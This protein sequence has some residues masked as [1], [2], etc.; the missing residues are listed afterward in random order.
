[1]RSDFAEP[2]HTMQEA[3]F[4]G[5]SKHRVF[6]NYHPA[7]RG[8]GRILAIICPPLFFEYMHVHSALRNLAI[9]LSEGGQ[10]VLRLDYRGTGDSFGDLE[11]FSVS[12]WVD[13]IKLAVQEGRKISGSDGVH[14]VAVRA[15]ALL[16]CRSMDA[17]DGVR[18]LVLWD[19]VAD[20]ATYLRELRDVQ[21]RCIEQHIYMSRADRVEAAQE[22][23][24]HRVSNRMIE[25]FAALD[26]NVYASIPKN[27]LYVICTREAGGLHLNGHSRVVIPPACDWAAIENRI[28][29]HPVMS[30]LLRACLAL[31]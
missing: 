18:R 7:V 15:G 12:D 14:V 31:S 6:A 24:G 9:R 2:V 27:K 29:I 3:F 22:C 23:A 5:E 20:G 30:E 26:A 28:T 19:P 21:A 8:D 10:N 17:L 13:D 4:L 25:D 11:E 1:L 16:A